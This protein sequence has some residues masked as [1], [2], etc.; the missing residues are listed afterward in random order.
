MQS[1]LYHYYFDGL[2]A[3]IT[4]EAPNNKTARGLLNQVLAQLPEYA[5]RELLE[6]T[7]SS[8]V[9]GISTMVRAGKKLVWNGKG[10]EEKR[11]VFTDPIKKFLYKEG[12]WKNVN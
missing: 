5:F 3:P 7:T 4:I 8:L 11:P 12:R 9:T 10:W 2:A 1:R 6:E